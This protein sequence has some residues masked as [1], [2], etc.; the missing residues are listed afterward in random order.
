[1]FL[2]RRWEQTQKSLSSLPR[3]RTNLCLE[4]WQ[5]SANAISRWSTSHGNNS[6]SCRVGQD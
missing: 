1:L 2:W 3:H 4:V 5:R 6:W